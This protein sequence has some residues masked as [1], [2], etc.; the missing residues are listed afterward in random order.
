M[1]KASEGFKIPKIASLKDSVQKGNEKL[2]DIQGERYPKR[3]AAGPTQ[4]LQLVSTFL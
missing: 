1:Q 4:Q 3:K 2:K